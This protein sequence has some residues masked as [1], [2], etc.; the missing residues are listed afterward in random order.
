ASYKGVPNWTD[1][2][3]AVDLEPEIFT[4]TTIYDALGRAIQ[5]TMPDGSVEQTTFNAASLLETKSV[6]QGLVQETIIQN[7]DYNETGKR[8]R[9]VLGNGVTTTYRYD[10]QSFSLL[11][12][13]S[14]KANN[15][16]LQ[17]LHYT[18]DATGNVTH[19]KD[20][21]VPITF[22][23]NQMITGL[24][25]YTYDALYQL[26][27]A[28]GRENNAALDFG[29]EDNWNDHNYFNDLNIGDPTAIRNYT[30]L[31]DYDEVGN[32]LQIDHQASGNNWMR[33]YI[34]AAGNNRLLG[35][36]V[37]S[38]TYAYVHHAQ[39]GFITDLPHLEDLSWNFK[40]K[41]VRSIRQKAATGTPE[42]TYYQYAADGQRLRKIT[43]AAAAAGETPAKKEE[44]VYI[45]SYELYK[46]HSGE[47]VGFHRHSLSVVDTTGRI[48]M[49][50]TRNDIDDGTEKRLVRYQIANHLGSV[51]LEVD[52]NANVISYEEYHPFGTTAY[53]ALNKAVHAAAKRYRFTGMERD[54]ETGLSYHSARYYL[55]WLGRWL[56]GDPS[57]IDDGLNVYRYA[58]NNPVTLTDTNGNESDEQ[59]A[60]RM[61][62]E[63]L[64][65]QGV[66]FKKEVPFRVEV[67]GK[68][69]EGRADFFVQTNSGKWEPVEMKGKAN[70]PW[71]K[72]QKEYLPALQKGAKFETIG[73]SKFSTPVT[74]SGGGKVF[75]VHTVAKGKFDFQKLFTTEVKIR[76][77][78]DPSK[79]RKQTIT[80]DV[81]GKV[82]S[83]EVKPDLS[84]PGTR[85]DADVKGL[86][87][88]GPK[89]P[90]GPKVKGKGLL[91][92]LIVAGG[93]LLFT[94]DAKAAGQSL[95][96]AADT[97]DAVI[98]DK[99]AAEIAAG[100]ALDIASLIPQVAIVR[101]GIAL[102]QAA[103]EA[104]HFP[105]PEGWVE[106]KVA[107]GR[108]PFCA[109]CH[110]EGNLRDKWSQQKEQERLL[111][112]LQQFQFPSDPAAD[113]ALLEYI[114]S[115]QKQ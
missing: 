13:T 59:K 85:L 115:M 61:F 42:T 103:M 114:K 41:L 58:Q 89:G 65:Q 1:A 15:Q 74:G 39:H 16:L 72:A 54:D 84:P 48:A 68:W 25:T 38:Q 113:A 18:F 34:Y 14:R 11:Q 6:T 93:I 69:V 107:E 5:V 79:N 97:T 64:T 96:P 50:E 105:V 17:D 63:F 101:T 88:K 98:E 31:Y 104:S 92:G 106:Q 67:N 87:V 102:N 32:I 20:R 35:T 83:S 66:N 23:N 37:G 29:P 44:R 28:T 86:K 55:P 108:N 27:K 70:S 53:R 110:G 7:I 40:E 91:G 2:N 78:A 109:I 95:N 36:K 73:T 30:E 24:S 22:F 76:N 19:V 82:V 57:G 26:I 51:N 71:T 81:E 12:V 43:E 8:L 90:K 4:T 100:V 56:S 3:L 21:A 60:S 46:K 33:D 99:G 52:A 94:G 47:H 111:G 62:E 49:I 9:L 80:K 10:K 77:P 112:N 45:G 75:N